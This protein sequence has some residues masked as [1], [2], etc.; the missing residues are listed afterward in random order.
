MSFTH[1]HAP[2]PPVRWWRRRVTIVAGLVFLPPIGIVL[3][4]IS[5]WPR[6]TKTWASIASLIWFVIV[7]SLPDNGVDSASDAKPA[8][9]TTATTAPLPSAAPTT[10][11]LSPSPTATPPTTPE[12]TAA[13]V[14]PPRPENKE[15]P[16]C[17]A[18][19][20]GGVSDAGMSL[21][22]DRGYSA[23]L[24]SN[25][26][27]MACDKYSPEDPYDEVDIGPS[28]SEPGDSDSGPAADTPDDDG[29]TSYANCS[30]VR[31]AGAAPIHEGDPGYSRHLD[32]DGD[33]V[34]CE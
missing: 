2:G 14:L 10:P 1:A 16:S 34:A 24:D 28:D 11:S 20:A 12:T 32:R 25:G 23:A 7:L 33:G 18:A 3:V 13:P 6:K 5:G 17:E 4:L 27:G 19:W 15:W 26:D 8:T 22:R 30:E 31:A 21:D 29:S 9:A